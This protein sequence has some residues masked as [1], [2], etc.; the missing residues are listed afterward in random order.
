MYNQP[1]PTA[2]QEI[3]QQIDDIAALT[4][5]QLANLIDDPEI[6][7]IASESSFAVFMAAYLSHYWNLPAADFHT[8]LIALLEDWKQELL[9][10]TGFRGSGKS[11]IVALAFV[12]WCALFEKAHFIILVNETDEVGKLSIANIRE[13]LQS[14]PLI[15]HDFG[16]VISSEQVSTKFSETNVLLANGVRI[17]ARS[18][19]QK[20]RGLRHRQY[21]PDL[22]IIDDCEEIDKVQSK[23][24]R[25]KTERWIRGVVI[26]AIEELKARLIIIGNELHRDALM[27]RLRKKDKPDAMGHI[28]T[29]RS[30]PLVDDKGQCNWVGKYPDKAAL[31]RQLAKVG[32]L[33]WLREYLLKVIPEDEQI[34]KDHEIHRYTELPNYIT[35]VASGVDLAIS[36]KQTADYTTMV[37][38]L[39]SVIEGKPKIYVLPKPINARLGFAQTISTMKAQQ[40]ALRAY[41][42]A[43]F[44]V[45][46]QSYQKAAIEV[47]EMHML[48][49]TPITSVADK[50]AKLMAIAPFIQNGTVLFPEAGCEELVDQIL[51]FGVAEHD[52]L[53]DGLVNLI[54]GILQNGGVQLP[55]VVILG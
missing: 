51:E 36:Q 23:I 44:Y 11:S 27:A 28:F 33:I 16:T 49:I 40:D 53:L 21:R 31:D 24:Y 17:M 38:G 46:A 5:E 1:L 37:A 26:P 8:E 50:R 47:G 42:M 34:V 19:G 18:R 30:Y 25:D 7:V 14:N 10:I 39:G 4:P 15:E 20:I 2:L 29:N 52:D 32:R 48:P 35:V 41:G 3:T 6:R 12:M 22:V 45:E 13:E 54:Y 9:A 43:M 55:E